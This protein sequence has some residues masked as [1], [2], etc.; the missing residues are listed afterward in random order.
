[1]KTLFWMLITAF[2]SY[3]VGSVIAHNVVKTE[4]QRLGEFYIGQTV[5]DCTKTEP[6]NK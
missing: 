6:S 3:N 2:M 4:C 5:Y 1:M